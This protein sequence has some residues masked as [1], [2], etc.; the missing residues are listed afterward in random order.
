MEAAGDGTDVTEGLILESAENG[1]STVS[2]KKKSKGKKAASS[3]PPDSSDVFQTQQE[4]SCL[5]QFKNC[6][7]LPRL[8]CASLLVN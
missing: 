7:R 5:T 2:H 1:W 6:I 3:P 8:Y 4:V